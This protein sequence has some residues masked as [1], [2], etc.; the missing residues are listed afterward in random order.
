MR[1]VG[2][3]VEVVE[4][5]WEVGGNCAGDSFEEFGPDGGFLEGEGEGCVPVYQ[6]EQ[7]R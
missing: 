5:F 1:F 4:W 3:E 6:A 2:G 7:R